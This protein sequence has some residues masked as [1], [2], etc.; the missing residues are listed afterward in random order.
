M[1]CTTQSEIPEG[2]RRFIFRA[3]IVTI[4][5]L[6]VCQLYRAERTNPPVVQEIEAP[7]EVAEILR[8]SC[9]DCHSYRTRWPWYSAVAPVSWWLA[10]HVEHGREHLNFSSWPAADADERAHALE[11][12]EE[13]VKT[14]EMPLSSYLLLH[15]GARLSEADRARLVDW[16][17]SGP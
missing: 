17:R 3:G 16:A 5:A 12:I 6:A 10:D 11:E 8:R 15:P 14:E 4:A 9:Y 2:M 13:Q 7:A 1:P